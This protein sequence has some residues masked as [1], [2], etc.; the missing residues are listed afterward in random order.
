MSPAMTVAQ[1]GTIAYTV[2]DELEF[3]IYTTQIDGAAP[4]VEIVDNAEDQPGRKLPP[5][6]PDRFSRIATYPADPETGLLPSNMVTDADREGY[7]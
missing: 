6:N 7:E 2:F 4:L 3:H 5:A 1:D